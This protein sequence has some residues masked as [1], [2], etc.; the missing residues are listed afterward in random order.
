MGSW[1]PFQ[2]A[3]TIRDIEIEHLA[4][5]IRNKLERNEPD[6]F[7]YNATR[8][9]RRVEMLADNALATLIQSELARH[10]KQEIICYVSGTIAVLIAPNAITLAAAV[11]LTMLSATA[12]AVVSMR[13]VRA[14]GNCIAFRDETYSDRLGKYIEQAAEMS[15]AH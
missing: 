9:Y 5:L 13:R 7:R 8:L 2:V 12:L 3:V 4:M 14:I 1:Y 11:L 10:K 6:A 15:T